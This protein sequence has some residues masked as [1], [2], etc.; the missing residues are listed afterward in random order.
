VDGGSAVGSNDASTWESPF[1]EAFGSKLMDVVFLVGIIIA[2]IVVVI[3]ILICSWKFCCRKKDGEV[4][5][6]AYV[7]ST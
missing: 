3:V 7:A 1:G 4:T 5:T 6:S 2:S